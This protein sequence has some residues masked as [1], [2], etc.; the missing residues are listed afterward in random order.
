[1]LV[2]VYAFIHMP[3]EDR[4]V[5]SPGATATGGCEAPDMYPGDKCNLNHFYSPQH[6]FLV[7]S[8]LSETGSHCTDQAG[9]ELKEICLPQSPKG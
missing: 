7:A 1:M 6:V 9:P 2:S 8:F 3:V 4:S 5:K